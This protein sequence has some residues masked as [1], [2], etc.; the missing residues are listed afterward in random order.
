M[1]IG[2]PL[3]L[4]RLPVWERAA[5]VLERADALTTG[6]SFEFLTEVHPRALMSRLEQL[7]PGQ[8][9][10]EYRH[11][12][13]CEWHLSLTRVHV[14]DGA[15]SLTAAFARSP[16]LSRLNDEARL[17][18][19]DAMTVRAARKGQVLC[20]ENSE[21]PELGILLEGA[22]GVFVGAGSRERSLFHLY[23][24]EFF[25]EIEFLDGGLSIGRITVLSKAAR[26]ATVPHDVVREA[27]RRD[28]DLL[29]A[30]SANVAQH[31][32]TLA[33]AL[34]AQ[35]SAPTLAR[36]ANAL[37]P[38][39]APERGLHPALA[40]LPTMTQAQVAASAGT[41]KEVAARAIAELERLE[42]LRRERGHI[43]Y[44][45]RSKLLETIE[46]S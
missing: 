42:T 33:S 21:C 4:R 31:N 40:P 25:G 41:V 9:A 30:L 34:A 44:L 29:A 8:L 5:I 3:D 16:V 20:A 15:S 32:R 27:G 38:Y 7:R 35:V 24:F 14:E 23:P 11:V 12:G 39:A 45:D 10:F 19:R 6:G 1:I 36:V 46:Q 26:Y 2:E 43:R 13:E 18:L 22:V 17:H 37:L 28:P